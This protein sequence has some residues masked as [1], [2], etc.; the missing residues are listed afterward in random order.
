[1]T[2][3]I[4]QKGKENLNPSRKSNPIGARRFL[5]PRLG[6]LGRE[7]TGD[8]VP[9]YNIKQRFENDLDHSFHL[10]GLLPTASSTFSINP[11][12]SEIKQ[13]MNPNQ[14]AKGTLMDNPK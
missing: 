6:L 12:T 5:Y 10:D 4:C 11:A 1:M 7:A 13:L 2:K 9:P 8:V 3:H 14:T